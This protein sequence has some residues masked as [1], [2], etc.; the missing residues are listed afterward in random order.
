M[1]YRVGVGTGLAWPY[2]MAIEAFSEQEAVDKVA[3]H[4][5]AMGSSF[6]KSYYSLFKEKDKNQ[7]VESYAESHNLICCGN[8]SEYMEVVFIVKLPFTEKGES[9]FGKCA[10]IPDKKKIEWAKK[11]PF[12]FASYHLWEHQENAYKVVDEVKNSNYLSSKEPYVNLTFGPNAVLKEL[13]KMLLPEAIPEKTF[14]IPV[15]WEMCGYVNIKAASIS[16]AIEKFKA[17]SDGIELPESSK[18]VDGSFELATEDE[19][20]IALYNQI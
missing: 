5:S 3:D 1:L 13:E 17:V 18:Y 6:V 12:H 10:A 14:K 8:N 2:T 15:V 4:L 20:I 9:A 16:K 7:T 11:S 19:G